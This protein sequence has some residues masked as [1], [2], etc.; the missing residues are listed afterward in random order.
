[1]MKN[2]FIVLLLLCSSSMYSQEVLDGIFKLRLGMSVEELKQ[3]VDTTLLKKK[4]YRSPVDFERKLEADG[5][6]QY[7]NLERYAPA[8]GYII[9]NMWLEFLDNKLYD[10]TIFKYNERTESLL[11]QKYGK[12]KIKDHKGTNIEYK[13]YAER[14]ADW[15]YIKNKSKWEV[16]E[17]KWETNSRDISCKSSH[18]FISESPTG[19][20]TLYLID[21]SA[22]M[23][24]IREQTEE[25]LRKEQEKID[26][27]GGQMKTDQQLIDEF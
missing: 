2:F 7:F 4:K 13:T 17:K 10:I 23:R 24:I 22:H 11:T 5:R 1:M 20:Y 19:S 16:I 18:S 6:L 27:M 8:Y 25:N 9:E 15:D 12:P 3:V 26:R 21:N 14:I